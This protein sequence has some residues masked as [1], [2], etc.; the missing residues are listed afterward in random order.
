LGVVESKQ[1]SGQSNK[2]TRVTLT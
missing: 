1:T 2:R